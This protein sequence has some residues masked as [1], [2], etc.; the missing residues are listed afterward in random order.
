MLLPVKLIQKMTIK[1]LVELKK[2]TLLELQGQ[3]MNMELWLS[4]PQKL[5]RRNY[6]LSWLQK[7]YVKITS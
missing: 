3:T 4:C 6:R 2:F 5:Q 7:Y 1:L